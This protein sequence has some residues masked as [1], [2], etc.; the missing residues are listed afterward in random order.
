[1]PRQDRV[2]I[3][4]PRLLYLKMKE[5][6]KGSSYNSVTD[7]V[8]YVLRDIVSVDTKKTK[9]DGLTKKEI[10]LIKQRLKNLGYL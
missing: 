9:E 1:M 5:T 2:T 10:S 7:F 8:I 6:I 3:K 4:I